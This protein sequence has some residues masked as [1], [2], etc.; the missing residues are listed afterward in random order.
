MLEESNNDDIKEPQ[1]IV[2]IEATKVEVCL[3]ENPTRSDSRALI[4]K[5][6]VLGK[7]SIMK[8][9]LTYT[10]MNF[11]FDKF[12]LF[13]C[14][15]DQVD[16]TTISIIDPLS[17]TATIGQI[18]GN[19]NP[20]LPFDIIVSGNPIHVTF[21]FQDLHLCMACYDNIL[22]LAQ[23]LISILPNKLSSRDQHHQQ[24]P[25]L[26]KSGSGSKSSSV[27]KAKPHINLQLPSA[28]ITVIDDGK[29]YNGVIDVKLTN[30]SLELIDNKMF[31]AMF[32]AANYFNN[33]YSQWEPLIEN[34]GFKLSLLNSQENNVTMN[35]VI[36]TTSRQLNL[37]L[38]TALF[39]VLYTSWTTF[40][41]LASGS[42]LSRIPTN[43]PFKTTG[44]LFVL[45][46]DTGLPLNWSIRS[47]ELKQLLPQSTKCVETGD[48][49]AFTLEE[50][51]KKFRDATSISTYS[52]NL[53]LPGWRQISHL[54][55]DRSGIHF[56]DLVSS[57]D[58]TAL[59]SSSDTNNNDNNDNNN[60]Q[61][62]YETHL[63]QH[64]QI[65]YE[66]I[67]GP[68]FRT[69]IIRSNYLLVNDTY[70]PMNE[71]IE[72]NKGPS[73]K[74][75]Q[76]PPR[77]YFLVQIDTHLFANQQAAAAAAEDDTG[78]ERDDLDDILQDNNHIIKITTPLVIENALAT[79]ISCRLQYQRSSNIVDE[80]NIAS[81]ASTNVHSINTEAIIMMRV[82]I[83]HHEW[84][85]LFQINLSTKKDIDGQSIT[86]LDAEKNR[87]SMKLEYHQIL[88]T[89]SLCFQRDSDIYRDYILEP[90]ATIPFHFLDL[91]QPQQLYVR[92]SPTNSWSGSFHI[93]KSSMFHLRLSTYK[94]N[95]PGSPS[96]SSLSPE[97]DD[98]LYLPLVQ[99]I[100]E[101]GYFFIIF[102][103]ESKECPPFKIE[104]LTTMP[105]TISQSDTG[106]LH[107]VESG[108]TI[109]YTWDDPRLEEKLEIKI[110]NTKF[111][112]SLRLDKLY[113]SSNAVPVRLHSG[114]VAKIKTTIYA[115]GPTNV[116]RIIDMNQAINEDL[117]S[118]QIKSMTDQQPTSLLSF[119]AELDGISLSIIDSEPKELMFVTLKDIILEFNNTMEFEQNIKFSIG[120]I[121]VDNQL[122]Y[123]MYPEMI[124]RYTDSKS[125]ND[126]SSQLPN[127]LTATFSRSTKYEYK[128]EEKTTIDYIKI[129]KFEVQPVKVQIDEVLL[130]HLY[131][132]YNSIEF[133][134]APPKSSPRGFIPVP[135]TVD[136][137]RM[138][139]ELLSLPPIQIRFSYCSSEYSS[140][141]IGS[142]GSALA[143]IDNASLYLESWKLEHQF[144][145]F[146]GLVKSLANHFIWYFGKVILYSDIFG[147]PM[148]LTNS[149]GRGVNMIKES[150]SMLDI[151]HG[152]GNLLKSS[153]F[154]IFNTASKITGSIGNVISPLA[155]DKNYQEMR[156]K[157]MRQNP[158]TFS[159]GLLSLGWG[160]GNGLTGIISQPFKE[161]KENGLLDGFIPGL[162]KGAVGAV[163]KT[164]VGVIDLVNQSSQGLRN[165]YRNPEESLMAQRFRPPRFIGYDHI[166][167]PYNLEQ[168]FWQEILYA[169]KNVNCNEYYQAHLDYFDRSKKLHHL[170]ISNKYL[171]VLDHSFTS[172]WAVRIEN[173]V[174]RITTDEQQHQLILEDHKNQTF[175]T[176]EDLLDNNNNDIS[177]A[178]FTELNEML[179]FIENR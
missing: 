155:M 148:S 177:M 178:L 2:H 119:S 63:E 11:C 109:R 88:G 24:Q 20:S 150:S 71:E 76:F 82:K 141:M 164:G 45:R 176:I 79:P 87:L 91:D 7:V 38:S 145:T 112:K 59:S 92:V 41:G 1:L 33:Q 96:S 123:T 173:L 159:Q 74:I 26:R 116:L 108:Q 53:K 69:L 9:K 126:N 21:S 104:N 58:T 118:K 25:N 151:V 83:E 40:K 135:E 95:N 77:H 30:I 127:M 105:I 157:K 128:S 52:L 122:Y 106:I 120:S 36:L 137:K 99:I 102:N 110:P 19:D 6:S 23:S 143:N 75:I 111:Y 44:N 90:G 98:N 169:L 43:K 16:S 167:R 152:T 65:A 133:F 93:T 124:S 56:F 171:Y 89:I 160:L 61:Q 117:E 131:T 47:K 35:K 142:V 125:D 174:V 22:T 121:K 101:K 55:V 149:L 70:K 17:V 132:F 66:I 51:P 68:R 84:S 113:T 8:S 115:N 64:Q 28:S 165:S 42:S 172:D 166:L 129:L 107:Q 86:L 18:E 103:P 15:L 153:I 10:D 72:F 3:I 140:A 78:A 29:G 5:G 48:E 37:N 114:Y 80:I 138:Y 12:E 144:T 147:A 161:I 134:K 62:E 60:N 14:R 139:F 31:I 57:N 32:V 13:K 170:L 175:Q 154:G 97:S 156:K 39:D 50:P 94:V 27:G 100:S 67:L 130:F 46:N 158:P 34:W 179:K 73:I 49:V 146:D 162:V 136:S 81:G 85:N 4:V 168:S 54:P 163:V